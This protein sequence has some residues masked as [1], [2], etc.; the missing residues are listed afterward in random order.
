MKTQLLEDIGQSA[1]IPLAPSTTVGKSTADIAAPQPVP[2][3]KT[4][5]ARPRAAL[6]V[7][8]Q[9]P[10]META[11]PTPPQPEPPQPAQPAQLHDVLEELA[12][13]EAQLDRPEQ[14]P[15][16][17]IAPA[18]PLPDAALPPAE[19][20]SPAPSPPGAPPPQGPLFDFTP[21]LPP[22]QAADPF[23]RPPPALTPSRRRY[24]LGAACVLSAALLMFGGRWLYQER[25]DAGSLA[26]LASQAKETPRVDAAVARQTIAAKESMPAPDD[27][28]YV[29]AVTANRPSS[30]LPPLVMLPPD[31]PAAIEPEQPSPAAADPIEPQPAPK[32]A[33]IA[34]PRLASPLPEPSSRKARRNADAAAV[35]A[36]ARREREPVPPL[37]RAST[38]R[39]EKPSGQESSLAETLRACRAHGYHATQ[40]IKRECSVTRYGFACRG[41]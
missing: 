26:L 4:P 8:R 7:W 10:A 21:P 34:K 32:A 12:A 33:P 41:R 13:L 16:P 11:V 22:A 40:C 27:D 39:A 29:P 2:A 14:Q 36:K 17:A 5:P 37:A 18:E 35:P 20:S 24:L 38:V 15:E 19:A 28:V 6:G 23:T 9:K 3:A 31:P 25:H 1:T 30:S